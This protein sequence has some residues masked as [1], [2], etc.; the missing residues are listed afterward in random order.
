MPPMIKD[1]LF[2]GVI[3]TD[4]GHTIK[5]QRNGDVTLELDGENRVRKI[6]RV[7]G[8]VFEKWEPN[9]NDGQLLAMEGFG[10][11]YEVLKNLPPFRVTEIRIHYGGALYC[12][13]VKTF[14]EHGIVKE[15]PG[16]EVK[17]YLEIDQF[18]KVEV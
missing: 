14:R 4:N 17:I 5:F 10:I 16:M 8:A 11:P 15:F 3:T 2:G 6:G 1:P 18:T 9:K 7:R 12:T 13:T